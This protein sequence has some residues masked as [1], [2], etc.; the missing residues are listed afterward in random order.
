MDTMKNKFR[1]PQVGGERPRVKREGVKGAT[2]FPYEAEVGRRQS[3]RVLE[4][5]PNVA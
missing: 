4:G 2:S 3:G 1:H 5:P